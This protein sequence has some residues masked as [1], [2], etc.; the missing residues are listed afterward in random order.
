[1]WNV[2]CLILLLSTSMNSI[3]S[4]V[5]IFITT[6]RLWIT[7]ITG[8]GCIVRRRPRCWSGWLKTSK[9]NS[10]LNQEQY[11]VYRTM[12]KPYWQRSE[13]DVSFTNQQLT[14]ISLINDIHKAGVTPSHISHIHA[15]STSVVSI[16]QCSIFCLTNI[17]YRLINGAPCRWFPSAATVATVLLIHLLC[18]MV[19]STAIITIT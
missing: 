15:S 6:S 3:I 9:D 11:R 19:G 5:S 2:K 16:G 14:V 8:L 12:R 1:M 17:I 4:W 7:Q 13:H 18:R 10:S